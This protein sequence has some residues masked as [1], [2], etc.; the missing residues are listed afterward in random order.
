MSDRGIPA[1]LR[2][3]HGFGSHTFK[4]TNDKGEGVWIKYHF[5]TEQG[6]KNLDVNTAAKSRAKIP[7]TIRK[8]CSMRLK[9]AISRMEIICS[10]HAVR[11]RKHISL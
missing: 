1:T 7:I 9:T 6:V 8:I 3:M 4:W 10:N 2:H 5:K 11:R